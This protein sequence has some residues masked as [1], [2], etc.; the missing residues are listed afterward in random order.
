MLQ[1]VKLALRITTSAF[2]GELLHLIASAIRDMEIVGII[3]TYSTVEAGGAITDYT[4]AEPLLERAIVTYCRVN[5]GQPD[6]YDKL[7]S[8]YDEQKAQLQ[9]AAGFREGIDG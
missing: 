9:Y 2:D 4:V 8:S 6:D 5:F 7:K 3:V 1:L